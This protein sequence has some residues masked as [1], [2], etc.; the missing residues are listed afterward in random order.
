MKQKK[1]G[2]SHPIGNRTVVGIICIVVALAICFGSRIRMK[3]GGYEEPDFE[4]TM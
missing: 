4:L 3:T 2:G 1:S